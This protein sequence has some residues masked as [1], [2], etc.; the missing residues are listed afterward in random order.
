MNPLWFRRD[1][2]RSYLAANPEA[3]DSWVA[4]ALR[5]QHRIGVSEETVRRDRHLWRL[6]PSGEQTRR[7]KQGR[8]YAPPRPAAGSIA[9]RALGALLERPMPLRELA[10]RLGAPM[11]SVRAALKRFPYFRAC[12]KEASVVGGA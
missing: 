1:L 7:R 10:T 6:P 4:D 3:P 11:P 5:T 2:V 12:A 9:Q 8:V